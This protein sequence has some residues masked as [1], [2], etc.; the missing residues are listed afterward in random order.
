M[1][2]L[3]ASIVRILTSE[4]TTAS[5]GFVITDDGLIATCAHV[6]EA[7]GAGTVV[8]PLLLAMS[9]GASDRPYWP[10]VGVCCTPRIRVGPLF[11][12]VHR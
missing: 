3:T 7:A 2:D 5:T 11:L 8:H 10:V 6:V 1:E 4:G 9:G 12:N